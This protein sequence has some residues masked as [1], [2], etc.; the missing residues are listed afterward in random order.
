VAGPGFPLP[1]S[2]VEMSQVESINPPVPS[3]CGKDGIRTHS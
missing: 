2:G 3:H 1:V